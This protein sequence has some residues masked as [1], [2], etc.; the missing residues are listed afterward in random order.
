[1]GAKKDKEDSEVSLAEALQTP[2]MVGI[3]D[4]SGGEGLGIIVGH[5]ARWPFHGEICDW[6]DLLKENSGAGSGPPT[7]LGSNT[8]QSAAQDEDI[9]ASDLESGRLRVGRIVVTRSTIHR[10]LGI[11]KE[12][13]R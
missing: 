3:I 8:G 10:A 11:P 4:E 13:T 7:P 1:M 5:V 9:K 6:P 2:Q 12:E